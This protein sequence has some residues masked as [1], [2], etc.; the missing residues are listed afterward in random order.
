MTSL[1][2]GS[3]VTCG[4]CGKET[5]V[6]FTTEREGGTAYDLGCQHRNGYCETCKKLVRDVSETIYEV[7]P[8]CTTC[9]GPLPVDDDE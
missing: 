1:A 3:A 8:H 4:M 5:S 2:Q 6:K 9:S 7:K